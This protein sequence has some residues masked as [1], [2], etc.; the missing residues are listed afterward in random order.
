MGFA[1]GSVSFRRFVVRGKSPKAVDQK[2]LERLAEHA[3][4]PGEFGV[5]GEEE[6]GWS[7]GRH[8]LDGSF[9]F[10]NNVYADALH[11]ALRIDTNKVPGELKKAWELME[12]DAVA[13]ENPS[14]FISKSQK[15]DV[16]ESIRQKIDDELR[17]GHY[18][19]S[20]LL[21]VLWDLPSQTVYSPAS[22]KSFEKLAE[23]FQ[24]TFGLDLE[25]VSAGALGL[26]VSEDRGK[27]R[28]YEDFRPTRFV[29]G[30]EGEGQ[31][32]EY[33]WVAKGPQPKDFLGNE[34]LLWLW[35]EAD[36]R[37][38]IITTERA[39]DVTIYLDK[40]L[41]LDCAYGQTGR[42]TLR[43]DGPT[44]MPEAR[45][46][47]RSGKLPRKAGMIIDANR[48]QYTFSF[49]AEQLSFGSTKLPDVEEA[50]NPRVMFEERVVLLRDLCAAIDGLFETFLKLRGSSAW[51]GYVNGLRRWIMQPVKTAAA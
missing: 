12:A 16:K 34:F 9:S 46:A 4:R 48:Q 3:L 50:E 7:G 31:H 11:F 49:N 15:K 23:I 22:G 36:S 13:A 28:D 32:P 43:G 41:D 51:E 10:E 29:Q 21:P 40:S 33:P 14:G 42:D 27:R 24:R 45:D 8:V 47:L 1:S 35:H 18:R 25:P 5:P 38:G 30:P 2:L 20:K 26:N 6:Y 44:R 37:T 19:R 17:A 39:G